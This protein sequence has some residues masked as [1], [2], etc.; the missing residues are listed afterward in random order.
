MAK[1]QVPQARLLDWI[2][3]VNERDGYGVVK[4]E[5]RIRLVHRFVYEMHQDRSRTG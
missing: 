3:P 5:G 1:D 2:G 4:V